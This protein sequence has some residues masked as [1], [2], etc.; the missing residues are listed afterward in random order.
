MSFEIKKVAVLG[1]GVMGGQIAAHL[2]NAKIP[3]LA[4][5]IDQE[6]SEKGIKATQEI[7]PAAFYNKKTAQLITPL[8]YSEH[9]SRISECDWVIEAISERLDWKKDLYSKVLEHLSDNCVITSNTSGISLKELSEDMNDNIK[10]RFFITHFF[11]PPRYMKLVEVIYP[12]NIKKELLDSVID[13]LENDLGKGVVHAKDTPNF[14]ANRIGIYGMMRVLNVAS[15]MKLSVEDIDFFTGSLI[16]RP[17]S[18]TFRTADIVGLDTMAYVAKTAFERCLDD[19]CRDTFNIPPYIEK[20]LENKW[21]GQKSGQ[22]F[23]K[24]I[25]KGVIHSLNLETLEYAPQNKKKYPGVRIAKEY[26]SIKDRIR[27]LCYSNDPSGK[28]TWKTVSST[29]AYSAHRIPEISDN[30]YSIDRSMEWGFGWDMGPFKVW[31]IIGVEKSIKRMEEENI[32]IPNWVRDMLS[33]GNDCFYKYIDNQLSYYDLSTKGYKPL[34][35]ADRA[36]NFMM[37]KKKNNVIRKNWSASVVDMGDEIIGVELHSILKEDLNPIDGSIMETLKYAKDWITE[38]NY[39]GMVISSDSKNFSAGANLNMILDFAEKKDYDSLENVINLMQGLMQ[40]L[41][42]APFPVIAAPF[43]LVLGGGFETI[44]ACDRIVASAESYIGLVEVG[45]G[46]IPGAG[47][48]LR[49][50]S[51]LTKKINTMVPGAFPIVQKAFETI[52]YAKVSFS[53]K[54]AQGYGYLQKDD[55]IVNNRDYLLS[56]AKDTAIKMSD[57]Y[58]TPEVESFKLPGVSGRL[59]ISTMVKGLVK[60]KKISEHDALIAGKLSYVLTGGEK[61]GPFSPVDEQYLLDIEREAFISLCGEQ[62]SIDRI[63]HMLSKGKPLRN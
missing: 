15:E 17:K 59:A 23:Y 28:F 57:E 27:N 37:L 33:D 16:G 2:T 6:T 31:D 53:A 42:F 13:I 49:M 26:T 8:N 40:E 36:M 48:N 44:G 7:K 43:G 21:L 61:G 10:N 41:R 24:K 12:D 45:V 20:M 54:Q 4:Y 51:R 55:I 56:T 46:L 39:K 11:N 60:T 38:H 1:T 5:D 29:L 35:I 14:I 25:D 50:I 32:K 19:E 3:V 63:K 9:I 18:G 34:P 58:E 22:G 47:G 62:K 52:G 30:I